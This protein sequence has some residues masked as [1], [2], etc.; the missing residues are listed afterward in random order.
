M[1]TRRLAALRA[2]FASQPHKTAE[3]KR[4]VARAWRRRNAARLNARRRARHVPRPRVWTTRPRAC[5]ERANGC[6]CVRCAAVRSYLRA[7]AKARYSPEARRARTARALRRLIADSGG[8]CHLCGLQVVP[9]SKNRALVPSIDHLVPRARGGSNAY[10]NL[11]L[12][13]QGCNAAKRDRL[14][15]DDAFRARRAAA[16]GRSA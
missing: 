3:E 12:A 4:A 11:A 9:G 15:V 16:I 6:Q 7:W 14:A 8:A 5:P 10:A 1:S 13:H 2:Y